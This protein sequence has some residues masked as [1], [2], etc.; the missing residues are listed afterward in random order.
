MPCTYCNAQF[1]IIKWKTKCQLCMKNHCSECMI[2][3]MCIPCNT[4]QSTNY[5][6]DLLMKLKVKEL[7]FYL[8][9]RNY[10][11]DTFKEKREFVRKIQA[12]EGIHEPDT[13]EYT[14]A[15]TT[16]GHP[17]ESTGGNYGQQ[18]ENFNASDV[19]ATTSQNS[20]T[21]AGYMDMSADTN[22]FNL[23]TYSQTQH[24]FPTAYAFQSS[25]EGTSTAASGF[26]PQNTE[27]SAKTKNTSVVKLSEIK[28]E[29][30]LKQLSIRQLKC[31]LKDNLVDCKGILEKNELY[32]KVLNLFKDNWQ[33]QETI[34][35]SQVHSSSS[36]AQ[37]GEHFCKI[38][39]DNPVD[40]VFLDCAHMVACTECSKQL[41][42]CPICRQHI[43]RTVRVF[44]S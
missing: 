1:S 44:K 19:H 17:Q 38:C 32:D 40:C 12:L 4:V 33:N 21:H 10:P 6:R 3:R 13:G 23:P 35:E 9:N 28:S 18:P 16:Q 26:D 39:W 41:K 29:E 30:D 14:S 42:E 11:T 31:L 2:N 7:K 43:V 20:E 37:S 34:D 27:T 25:E 24:A 15:Y 36:A 22:V 8:K 5:R